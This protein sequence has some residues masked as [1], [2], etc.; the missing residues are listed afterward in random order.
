MTVIKLSEGLASLRQKVLQILEESEEP[1][2]ILAIK[3]R[4]GIGH[5]LSTKNILLELM[6]L[7]KVTC[8]R[9]TS[10]NAFLFTIKNEVKTSSSQSKNGDVKVSLKEVK[11]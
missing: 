3:K 5:W 1:L 4:A 8:K 6:L 2:S 7:G 11:Q 10:R 9:A